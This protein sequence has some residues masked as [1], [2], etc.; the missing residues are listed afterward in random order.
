MLR[1]CT[2]GGLVAGLAGLTAM[3]ATGC[4]V[5]TL[6]FEPGTDGDST[7]S[8]GGSDAGTTVGGT[9]D[10]AD[11]GTVCEGE[12]PDV[13]LSSSNVMLLIDISGSTVQNSWDHDGDPATD[14]LTRWHSMRRAISSFVDRYDPFLRLGVHFFPRLDTPET[15][16][17]EA[18]RTEVSPEVWIDDQTAME[19]EGVL[20]DPDRKLSGATPT[21]AAV[22]TGVEHLQSLD[23]DPPRHMILVTDGAPAY[24]GDKDHIQRFETLD[25][26]LA[27]H[28]ADAR[29]E[30]ITTHVVGLEVEDVISGCGYLP[31]ACGRCTHNGFRCSNSA[32][33][34]PQGE[35]DPVDYADEGELDSM[36]LANLRDVLNEVA[37]AGGAP[38]AGDERFRNAWNET[39]LA[40]QLDAI[41][42]TI[43]S[44]EV[45]LT[46]GPAPDQRD[47]VVVSIGDTA[48]A[49]VA[50]CTDDGWILSGD[51]ADT[52]TLCGTSCQALVEAGGW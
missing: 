43:V 9:P 35:C 2:R 33:C 18:C 6:G 32:V 26:A 34:A 42:D 51:A 19:I 40:Q 28:V 38:L 1:T 48:F 37:D 46:P 29:A 47:R 14:P 16:D 39:E 45:L 7:G 44:C 25:T 41:A 10:L 15:L 5:R 30:E 20:P 3:A 27:G 36:P 13:Q 11:V 49:E 31:P 24:V 12:T 4:A 21:S 17:W 22:L 8:D 52:I 50:D 23:M